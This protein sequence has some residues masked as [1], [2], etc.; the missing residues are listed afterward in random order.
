MVNPQSFKREIIGAALLLGLG[1]CATVNLPNVTQDCYSI[2]DDER[3]LFKRADEFVEIFD[4]SEHVYREPDLEGYLNRVAHQLLTEDL[5]QSGIAIAVKVIN[6]PSFNALSLPNGRIYI[7]LGLLAALDNEAQLA[8]LLAHEMT[9]V[10]HRHALKQFR[11]VIN[12]SA[13]MS[14]SAVAAGVVAGAAGAM[15][16]QTAVI[17]SIYGFSK[18]LEFEADE[19]GFQMI[20]R[21][22]YDVGE[23]K[24][25]FEHLKEFIE[26]EDVKQPFFFS[27]HPQVVGRIKK[28]TEL[29]NSLPAG[30]IGTKINIEEFNRL[31]RDIPLKNVQLCLQMGMFKTAQR[32]VE[33]FISLHPAQAQGFFYRGEIY[34][35]RQDPKKK[36][37]TRDKSADYSEALKAYDQAIAYDD[38]LALAYKGKAQILQ[39]QG[40]WN[41]AKQAYRR[42]LELNL[43]AEDKAY[44]EQFLK[45]E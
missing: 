14:V 29:L 5:R 35:Q 44:I 28:Y 3:R 24:K 30:K 21:N 38:R 43:Q 36:E 33:K 40:V 1:G 18:D 12:K 10:F 41:E 16:V 25:T 13:L 32:N 23:S 19:K 11:S 17:S 39:K 42:Y 7:H 26:E 9:H 8:T 37:K 45:S 2:E 15:L 31:T 4:P 34:R 27:T 22:G 6:D 20:A